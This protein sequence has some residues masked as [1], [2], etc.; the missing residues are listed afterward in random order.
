M[1]VPVSCVAPLTLPR[2]IT[3][4]SDRFGRMTAVVAI[5]AIDTVILLSKYYTVH[6]FGVR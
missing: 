6:T 5:D 4:A 3:L 2:M 1:L